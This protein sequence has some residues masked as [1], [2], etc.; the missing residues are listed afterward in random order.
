MSECANRK[1]VRHRISANAAFIVSSAHTTYNNLS[2]S[3][4]GTHDGT[5][6]HLCD[7]TIG[8]AQLLGRSGFF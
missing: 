6:R 4:L 3:P 5:K 2:Y 7:L 1:R 8:S